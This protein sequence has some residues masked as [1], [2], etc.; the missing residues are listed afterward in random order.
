MNEWQDREEAK[1]HSLPP[2]PPLTSLL[3]PCCMTWYS[4]GK[5]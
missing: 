1:N 5:L 2:P 4:R 3:T